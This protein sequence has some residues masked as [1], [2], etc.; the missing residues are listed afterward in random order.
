MPWSYLSFLVLGGT[1]C[2]F[3]ET[4]QNPQRDPAEPSERPPQSPLRG[5][6]PRRASRRVVPLGWWPSRTLEH[7][8]RK[9]A[10]NRRISLEPFFCSIYFVLLIRQRERN[11]NPNFLVWI[12]SGG[13]GGSSTWRG[14]GLKV[15]YLPR[16]PEKPNS[17]AGYPRI[18][19]GY[20][21]KWGTYH[22]C[23]RC[24]KDFLLFTVEELAF[25]PRHRPGVPGTPGRPGG[26]Q[27]FH[28]IVRGQKNRPRKKNKFLG[29]EVPRNFSDQC[30]LDFAYFLCLFSGRRS[31]SSQELCSWE[32][33]FLILG[34]FSP[35]ELFLMCLYFF[36]FRL[37]GPLSLLKIHWK[38]AHEEKGQNH[39][40]WNGC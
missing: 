4:L 10:R 26:F 19:S 24:P 3:K 18:L 31:K 40:N 9:N 36:Y 27:K 32:L 34:G 16:N 33:F 11:P 2:F 39:P 23:G 38:I 7:S 8:R 1:T 28:V 12:F 14:G 17:L 13:V 5:K 25:L 35:C 15:R 6:F 30:S 29:T 22:C 37:R 21:G 20:P